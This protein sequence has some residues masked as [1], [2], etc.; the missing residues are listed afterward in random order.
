MR[1]AYLALIEID[2]AGACLVHAR[3]IAEG[4]AG[5]GHE[6]T[7]I[8]PRPLRTQSWRGV[9]H[10]WVRWWGFDRLKQWAFFVESA[11]HL[12]RLH[13]QRRFD[14]LFVGGK[15]RYPFPPKFVW[16]VGVPV[17]L[18][19]KGLGVGG[20]WVLRGPRRGFCG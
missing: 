3:E 13:R 19:G 1:I 16:G 12:W 5:L 8:L 14:L 20:F 18:G 9:R 4:L 10:V 11:W 17:F 2:V 7:M 15:G 6:M